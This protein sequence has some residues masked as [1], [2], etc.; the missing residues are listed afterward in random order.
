MG[1]NIKQE[2]RGG[3]ESEDGEHQTS[4]IHAIRHSQARVQESRSLVL[5]TLV[6]RSRCYNKGF[7][8]YD[9]S[10]RVG[11]S[12]AFWLTYTFFSDHRSK[13][14]LDHCSWTESMARDS[15]Y[16]N[17]NDIAITGWLVSYTSVVSDTGDLVCVIRHRHTGTREGPVP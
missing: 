16:C 9:M 6:E 3:D 17:N 14:T 7:E 4:N 8:R 11:R 15:M 10:S 2:K 1:R 5:V 13:A 12:P